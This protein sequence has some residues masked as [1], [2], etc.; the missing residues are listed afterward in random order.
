MEMF[1]RK[2]LHQDRLQP[3]FS[4]DLQLDRKGEGHAA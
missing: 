1:R 3:G 4:L 2:H